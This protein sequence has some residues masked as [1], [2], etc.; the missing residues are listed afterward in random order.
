MVF[1]K[2]RKV[3]FSHENNLKRLIKKDNFKSVECVLGNHREQ[4]S[5]P[6]LVPQEWNATLVLKL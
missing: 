4:C 2:D 1:S 5:I 6:G 3:T